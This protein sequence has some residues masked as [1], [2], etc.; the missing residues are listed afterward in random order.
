ML[1]RKLLHNKRILWKAGIFVTT[2]TEVRSVSS[3]EEDG[4]V[5]IISFKTWERGFYRVR[6]LL[7]RQWFFAT[8]YGNCTEYT[9][10]RLFTQDVFRVGHPV[11]A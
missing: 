10:F 4:A 11:K 3:M 7:A 2:R 9:F 6:A 1:F 5:A 8:P